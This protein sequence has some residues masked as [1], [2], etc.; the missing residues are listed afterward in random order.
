VEQ[1]IRINRPFE[2]PMIDKNWSDDIKD[3]KDKR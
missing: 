2:R 3:M 1:L